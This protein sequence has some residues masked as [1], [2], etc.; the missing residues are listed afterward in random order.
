EP[1][2]RRRRIGSPAKLNLTQLRT[3]RRHH[4]SNK[5]QQTQRPQRPSGPSSSHHPW[6][7]LITL[8]RPSAC[9]NLTVLLRT[10]RTMLQL[11]SRPRLS[12]GLFGRNALLLDS[13]AVHPQFILG[14]LFLLPERERV[15]T[16]VGHR[17]LPCKPS[18]RT[19][20]AN[21]CGGSW[22]SS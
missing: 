14:A 2:C 21:G 19:T 17:R 15:H 8:R 13:P 6:H 22:Q 7:P 16:A 10:E 5:R 1:L 12:V 11:P 18:L 3:R 20:I 9:V 4:K